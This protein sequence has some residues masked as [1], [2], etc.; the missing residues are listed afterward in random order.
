MSKILT[1]DP[2]VKKILVRDVASNIFE[3]KLIKMNLSYTKGPVISVYSIGFS[4][5]SF[6]IE[7]AHISEN[8]FKTL[9]ENCIDEALGNNKQ[10]S[11]TNLVYSKVS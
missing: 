4:Q 8:Q 10:N 11:L 1:I 2:K 9:A 5:Y 3:Q 6:L 7:S